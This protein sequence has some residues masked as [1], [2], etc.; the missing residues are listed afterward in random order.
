MLW[1]AV[2]SG[3]PSKVIKSLEKG[4]DPNDFKVSYYPIEKDMK[5]S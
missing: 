4:A 1:S 3:D 2:A 5:Q